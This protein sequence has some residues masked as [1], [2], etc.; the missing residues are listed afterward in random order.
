VLLE[1]AECKVA[2]MANSL[3]RETIV[4]ALRRL[5]E[6][7]QERGVI[8]ELC[9]L[10]GTIMVLAFRA[11]AST[12]DVDAIFQPARDVREAAT[13][14]PSDMGLPDGWLND[15][16]KK[17]LSERHEETESDLPQFPG[18]RVTAPTAEYMLAMKCMASRLAAGPGERGDEEDIRFL[19]RYLGL[20]SA[21]EAMNVV[22]RYYPSD[23]IPPRTQFLLEDIFSG[24]RE[25]A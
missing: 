23:R 4:A 16:A 24:Q 9:L 1:D 3:E 22:E 19:I 11:R 6:I 18:L 15:G 13:E 21:E 20:N 5:D 25:Q 12:K 7:L 2:P 10:G 8:G 14:V 17:S